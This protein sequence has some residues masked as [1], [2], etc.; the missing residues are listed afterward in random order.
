MPRNATENAAGFRVYMWPG[1]DTPLH[2]EYKATEPANL[3]SVTSIKSLAGEHYRLVNW[4]IANVV[5]LAMGVRKKTVIG[6]RGGISEKY[7]PDG[8]APGEFV[9]RMLE[10]TTQ[11]ERDETRRWLR[12][13]A[14]EPRDIA[15]VRGSVVHKMIEMNLPMRVIDRDVIEQ[16]M[17]AQWVAEKRK[18]KLAF[19]DD[20]H[21]FVYNGM[22]NYWD[23]RGT[24]P[25]VIISQEPQVF[26]LRLGYGGSADCFIWFLGYWGR[27][28]DG[29]VTFTKLPGA[30]EM[31]PE[32]QRLADKGL[33]TAE[34]IIEVGG[35][36]AVGDWKTSKGVYTGHVIQVTAYLMGEFVGYDGNIDAR[37]SDILAI[38]DLGAVFHI[39][40]DGWAYDLFE[41]REDAMR[42]FAGSV[43]YAR[44]LAFYEEPEALFIYSLRGRAPGT[45]GSDYADDS[46]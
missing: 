46:E 20:D 4:K 10:V 38:A 40:P 9:R 36:V 24:V 39:R 1:G 18:D 33:I 11:K 43:A 19:T 26:N 13:T 23:M 7:V 27:N 34:K 21:N 35:Q 28:E 32:M 22:A 30:D 29:E 17:A 37:L 8:E 15:A 16:R 12:Q 31:L 41:L 45:E 44:F 42:G 25:F 6:P 5:N 2:H 14:D 3:L